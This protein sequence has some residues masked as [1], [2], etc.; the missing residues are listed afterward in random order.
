[1]SPIDPDPSSS[2]Q[3]PPLMR[4]GWG[5]LLV[6]GA[7]WGA[8]FL[9]DVFGKYRHV[10][11]DTYRM[12]WEGGAWLWTHLAGGTLTVLLGPVQFLS[13]W[14][15]AWPLH[16]WTGRLFLAGMLVGSTGAVGTG[17]TFDL[18]VTGDAVAEPTG[19]LSLKATGDVMAEGMNVKVK[20]SM[21]IVLEATAGITLKVGGSLVNI[22]PAGVDIVG[23]MV[24]INSG[25]GGGSAGSALTAKKAAPDKAAK[26][27]KHDP[28]TD[29]TY[30][31]RF[32]DPMPTEG[33]GTKP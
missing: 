19:K 23:P 33:G 1:M 4:I 27:K 24:K 9:L 13:R 32:K 14:F 28:L 30:K 3:R 16:R 25:G 18:K 22:G 29:N 21:N 6:A 26:P 12:F 2:M 8:D 17:A 11:P 15:R 20:G 10:A 31:D 7:A 5:L